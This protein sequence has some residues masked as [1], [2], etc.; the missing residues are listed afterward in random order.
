[1]FFEDY[2]ETTSQ[3]FFFITGQLVLIHIL[4][5]PNT[6]CAL[7]EIIHALHTSHI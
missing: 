1:M 5:T 4:A 3:F 7:L 6:H 2:Y